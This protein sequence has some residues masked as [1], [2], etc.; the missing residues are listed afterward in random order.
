MYIV[1]S[2]RFESVVL[3]NPSIQNCNIHPGLRPLKFLHERLDRPKAFH[4]NLHHL[5]LGRLELVPDTLGSRFTLLRIP[6][7]NDHSRLV[8]RVQPCRLEAYPGVGASYEDGLAGEVNIRW[9][10]WDA[11]RELFETERNWTVRMEAESV[12]IEEAE[13]EGRQEP[14]GWKG[15][16][17]GRWWTRC[18]SKKKCGK[19]LHPLLVREG[20]RVYTWPSVSSQQG[21]MDPYLR[22]FQAYTLIYQALT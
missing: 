7:P 8:L 1:S 9:Y 5:D 10:L 16:G 21:S 22:T 3:G 11:G 14:H 18:G 15:S 4:V 6:H 19:R 20:F 2:R 17:S 13:R 12:L